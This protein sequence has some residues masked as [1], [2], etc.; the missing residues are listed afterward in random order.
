MKKI[1]ITLAIALTVGGALSA[2]EYWGQTQREYKQSGGS[3]RGAI[4]GTTTPTGNPEIAST[5]APVGEGL[6]CLLVLGGAYALRKR[7]SLRA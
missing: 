2:Q 3:L 5:T 1:I 4:D 6:L 7:S